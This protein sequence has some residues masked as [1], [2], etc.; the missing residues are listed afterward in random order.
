[1]GSKTN[2][3]SCAQSEHFPVGKVV[4]AHGLAGYMKIRP[5]SNNPSLLLDIKD[6]FFQPAME[7]VLHCHVLDVYLE[8]RILFLKVQEMADRTALEPLIGAEAH[9][10]KAQ[11]RKLAED[12]WWMTDLIGLPVFTTDGAKIGTVCDIIGQS[13]ELLEIKRDV[14]D[15]EETI[16][17]PFVK[18]LVPIVDVLGG[19]IEVVNLPGLLD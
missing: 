7:E 9:T 4:G 5:S 13:G 12:E 15:N 8:R 2:D 14:V 3:D 10:L 18:A 19:R 16:L 1:M 11:V 17:V 6:I